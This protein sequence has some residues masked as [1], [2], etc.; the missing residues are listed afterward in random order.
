M[1]NERF[2]YVRIVQSGKD[3]CCMCKN[4]SKASRLQGGCQ[5]ALGEQEERN[6][7]LFLSHTWLVAWSVTFEGTLFKKK[8]YG[9]P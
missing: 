4:V 7:G 2:A 3:G 5:V 9:T 1:T 8:Q 6:P